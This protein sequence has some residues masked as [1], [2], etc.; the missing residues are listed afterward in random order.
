MLYYQVFMPSKSLC[1]R[2]DVGSPERSRSGGRSVS[3]ACSN[4]IFMLSYTNSDSLFLGGSPFTD[5]VVAA[6]MISFRIDFISAHVQDFP[7]M[8]SN[9][10][11]QSPTRVTLSRL[12]FVDKFTTFI[13]TLYI[14]KAMVQFIPEPPCYRCSTVDS[15]KLLPRIGGTSEPKHALDIRGQA[16]RKHL[17]SQHSSCALHQPRRLRGWTIVRVGA[18]WRRD[19]RDAS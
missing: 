9:L 18:R 12:Y 16:W 10:C 19:S 1:T 8:S 15:S 3:G 11:Y 6:L 14:S 17:A 2:C 7:A 4:L 5:S 13:R